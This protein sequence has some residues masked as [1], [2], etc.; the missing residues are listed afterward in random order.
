VRNFFISGSIAVRQFAELAG[1]RSESVA[2][3]AWAKPEHLFAPEHVCHSAF[4]CLQGR[5][6]TLTLEINYI[7]LKTC[8]EDEMGRVCGTQDFAG[9]NVKECGC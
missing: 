3:R 7:V 4:T 8:E 9:K 6:L 5:F 1:C 2:T